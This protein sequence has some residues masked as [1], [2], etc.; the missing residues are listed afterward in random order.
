MENLLSLI[1]R[2]GYLLV[3]IGVFA[4]AIGLPVPAAVVLVTAGAAAAGGVLRAPIVLGISLAAMLTG[5]CLLFVLGRYTGWGLLGFLCRVSVNPETCILRSAE[6]F[7][8]RGKVALVISKFI[9]GVNTMAAPL[10]GSMMM[11]PLQFVRF[12]LA[13][14]ALYVGSYFAAGYVFRDFLTAL[15]RGFRTTG[16]AMEVVIAAALVA[17]IVYR[18]W[19]YRTHSIYRV[20]P[21]V[22]VEELARKLASEEKDR[23]LLVDVRSHGYYDGGALRLKGSVRIEPNNLSEE[24]ALLPKDRDLYLYCT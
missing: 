16:E 6:T 4:E 23:L 12:D 8:K 7:Y 13:G 14:V 22:Q 24:V 15:V 3:C 2:H 21:R 9:P 5:D 17:Y 10:A 20:V 19:L 1:G 11:R 18:V